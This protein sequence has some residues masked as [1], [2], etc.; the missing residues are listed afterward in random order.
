M[1]DRGG[2]LLGSKKSFVELTDADKLRLEQ[3]SEPNS[4][5]IF[6]EANEISSLVNLLK[7][8]ILV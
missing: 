5:A 2:L 6:L 4:S 1:F 8:L 7:V 3:G